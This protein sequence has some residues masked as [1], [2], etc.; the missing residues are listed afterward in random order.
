MK[1]IINPQKILEVMLYIAQTKNNILHVAKIIYFAEKMH[2]E[3]YGRMILGDK[4]VAM[5]N[6]P[7]PSISYDIFKD[8]RDKRQYVITPEAFSAFDVK[9]REIHP[10]RKANLDFLSETE[11]ECLDEAISKYRRMSPTKLVQI[12]HDEPAYKQVKIGEF[13]PL[14]AI[15]NSLTNSS[16][17]LD[18]L[19]E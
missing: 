1:E 5:D 3:R 15:I 14:V 10:L 12:A 7:V 13:I 19:N 9:G 18:Y 6:G 4:Y 2:L 11:V 8:V 16:E 17:I